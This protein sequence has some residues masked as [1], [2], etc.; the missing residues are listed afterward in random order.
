MVIDIK[1]DEK[2]SKGL[3]EFPRYRGNIG[4]LGAD[5]ENQREPD[6][7]T[8]VRFSSVEFPESSSY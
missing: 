6:G 1:L 7:M 3:F 4:P 5:E 8:N 2:G